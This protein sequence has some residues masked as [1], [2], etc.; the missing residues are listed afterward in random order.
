[1]VD[2]TEGRV[3]FTLLTRDI[4]LDLVHLYSARMAI[5]EALIARV[6]PTAKRVLAWKCRQDRLMKRR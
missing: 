1:V 2:V 4:A 5:T 6:N 3:N